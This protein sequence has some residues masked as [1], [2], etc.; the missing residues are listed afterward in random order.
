MP[1]KYQYAEMILFRR[2]LLEYSY[3]NGHCVPWADADS[4]RSLIGKVNVLNANLIFF[5]VLHCIP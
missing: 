1:A 4:K 2:R 3:L 5:F